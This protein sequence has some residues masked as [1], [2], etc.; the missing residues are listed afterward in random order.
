[1]VSPKGKV[2]HCHA[3][4]FNALPELAQGNILDEKFSVNDSFTE[5]AHF[6]FCNP[7]D[8]QVKYDRFK[9]YGYSAVEIVG[10]VEQNP[11]QAPDW[12]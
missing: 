1:L 10:D 2:Y 4:L 7:C 9:R 5:C 3:A 8:V 12:R 11:I 6:G